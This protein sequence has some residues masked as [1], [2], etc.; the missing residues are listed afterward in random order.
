MWS[1][2]G[3][4]P[5]IF[6]YGGRLRQHLI[7]TVDP[8]AGKVHIAFSDS[9]KALQFQHFL[10]GLLARYKD[11]GKV[12][13]VL[14]NA[15]AHHSKALEPF[16]TANKNKLELLFLPPYSPNMNPMEWFWKF[17]RNQVTHN[18]FFSSFV[19]FQRALVKFIRKFKFSSVEIKTRCSFAKLLMSL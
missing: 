5:E 11:A 2:K 7:G 15:R 10:E 14:D 18:T 8:L 1:L 19:K 6:T 16:L 17:L 9:L 3:Q 13:L 4:Q 12:L